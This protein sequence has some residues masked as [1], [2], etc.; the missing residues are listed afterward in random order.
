VAAIAFVVACAGCAPMQRVPLDVGPGDVEVYVDGLRVPEP[1]PAELDLKSNRAHVVF[2]KKSGHRSEQIVL[3]SEEPADGP[4]R[5]TP[6]RVEVEL[7]RETP[8]GRRLEV[9]LDEAPPPLPPGTA[10]Q[11]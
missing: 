7:R 3:R 10:V 6:D 4:P 5:L 9:E 11:P 8:K 2:V 1:L